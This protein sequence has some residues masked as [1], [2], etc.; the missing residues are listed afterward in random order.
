M[1]DSREANV[2]D[3]K[4]Q[5]K[6]LRQLRGMRALL[7][8]LIIVMVIGFGVVGYLVIRSTSSIDDAKAQIQSIQSQGEAAQ[9][10][11]NNACDSGLLT[12]STLCAN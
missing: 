2:M 5:K 4:M 12:N 7:G 10:L 8:F 6:L 1:F 11:K 9:E 3:E